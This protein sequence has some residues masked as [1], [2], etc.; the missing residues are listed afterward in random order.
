[1]PQVTVWHDGNCPLCQKEIAL[2]RRLDW[3]GN[4]Q[5][6]DA[7]SE[8]ADCPLSRHE[9]L[10]RFHAREGEQIYDGAAAFAAMW[11]AIPPLRLL[12][13]IARFPLMLRGL[14]YLYGH[15]LRVRPVLQKIMRKIGH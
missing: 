4:I 13:E 1:M 5:F 15:F 8:T 14:E 9:L 2:M 7:T 3:R 6:I 11:R 12:G 10:E